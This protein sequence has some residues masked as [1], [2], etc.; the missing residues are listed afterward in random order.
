MP[1]PLGHPPTCLVTSGKGLPFSEPP[2]VELIR[3]PARLP[4]PSSVV[5]ALRGVRLLA[6]PGVGLGLR[7]RK[8]MEVDTRGAGSLLIH[9]WP[10][11]FPPSI[12]HCLAG[13]VSTAWRPDPGGLLPFVLIKNKV[14]L[15][16]QISPVQ[17]TWKFISKK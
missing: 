11:P 17:T 10:S 5:S 2:E 13:C 12:P 9:L 16:Y 4:C 14:V 3:L 7:L 15:I 8:Q 1:P 6:G